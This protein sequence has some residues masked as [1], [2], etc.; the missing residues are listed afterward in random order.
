MAVVDDA[1]I[2][3]LAVDAGWGDSHSAQIAT[4]IALAESGGNA[5]ATNHNTNGSTD[6]GLWQINSIHTDVLSSGQWSDPAANAKM[7]HTVYAQAGNSFTPWVTYTTGR[8][9]V[10]MPRAAKAESG[11]KSGIQ[12]QIQQGQQNLQNGGGPSA[13]DNLTN[14]AFWS[15]IAYAVVGGILLIWAAMKMTGNNQLSEG[16]KAIVSAG[17]K[18]AI[19]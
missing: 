12:N 3:A 2:F 4:A 17:A 10:Y 1:T 8:Y 18:A 9:L 7:A 14:P 16:T 15:R 11:I 6:Y 19:A 13:M 5:S